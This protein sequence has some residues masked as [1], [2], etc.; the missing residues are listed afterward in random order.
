M[1]SIWIKRV[2]LALLAVALVAGFGWALREQPAL[3]DE[4]VV[5]AA[6]MK[7][8]IREEGM[9]RVRDVYAV[10]AP[11]AGHL[12]RTV[13]NEGDEVQASTVV[14]S[15]HPLDPPLIDRRAEAEL[16]AS[17]DA[18]RAGVGVAEIDLQRAQSALK[19]A[20]DE[21]ARTVKLF[22]SGFVSESA[23]QRLT[24]E[25]D[26]QKNAV[27]A[28]KAVIGLRAAELANAEAR[29]L[30]PDP[31]DPTGES[32]CVNLRA[33]IDGTVL[34]VMARS[35][36]AVAAGAKIAEIG[37]VHD[38]E[39]AVDLLSSDAVRIA[40][41]TKAEISDWGGDHALRATVR[42][43]DPAAFT[44]VSALGIE[45]QR[46][47]VVLDLE[48]TDVRLGHGYRVFVEMTVWECAECVQVPIGA[49][50][51]NGDRWNVFVADGGRARQTDVQ[52]GHMND[53]V[54]EVLTGLEPG[55]SVVVHPSDTLVDEGLVERRN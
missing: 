17:R 6:P 40:S 22:G 1:K 45:E 52:I 15:I 31:A 53:D 42:R 29:L 3:V 13:V 20:Q 19:L 43:V 34:A 37:N 41:G 14:A 39:I 23:L 5:T 8:T 35:E 44:K 4:A 38:L 50:F 30:Q 12:T 7:V 32:C 16:L 2:G 21:L 49:L 28:A 25:V 47:T 27:D 36:Q 10:S 24:N 11:I 9:T 18:A 46:V 51:R 54:A 48:D 55:V 26:L 33:P